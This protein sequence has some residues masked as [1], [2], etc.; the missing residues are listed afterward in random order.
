VEGNN[1]IWF[2]KLSKKEVGQL[3]KN[4]VIFAFFLFLAFIFWYNNSLGKEIRTDMKYN[5]NFINNLKGRIVSTE[6]PSK[7]TLEMKGQGYSLLKRKISGNR[8]SLV[9][10]LSKVIIKK[11][12]DSKPLK[13]YILSAGLIPNFKKQIGNG[14]EVYSVKPDTIFVNFNNI[15]SVSDKKLK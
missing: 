2:K 6:L 10:D 7:V 13:Y 1:S 15:E 12:P 8:S 5:V 9:V 3:N 11:V 14:F 4:I